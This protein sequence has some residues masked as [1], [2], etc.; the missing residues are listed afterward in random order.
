MDVLGG[1]SVTP[2]HGDRVRRASLALLLTVG[3]VG[4]AATSERDDERDRFIEQE[5]TWSPCPEHSGVECGSLEVPVDH[6]RPEGDTLDVALY[7]LPGPADDAG[8]IV[9]LPGGPGRRGVDLMD[10]YSPVRTLQRTH[11]VV[12]YDARAIGATSSFLCESEEAFRTHLSLDRTPDTAEEETA[13]VMSW[14]A[15]A[16]GCSDAAGDL[17][18]F[19]GTRDLVQDLDVLRAALGEDSL[20]FYGLSYGTLVGSEY[21]RAFPERV[22]RAALDAPR[23]AEDVSSADSLLELADAAER[24]FDEALEQCFVNPFLPCPLG[25]TP[26]EARASVESLLATLDAEPVELPDGGR[27]TREL[28]VSALHGGV[29]GGP[30]AWAP[31]IT[32]LGRAHQGEWNDLVDLTGELEDQPWVTAATV[33]TCA[34]LGPPQERVPEVRERARVLATRSPVF[35]ET[36]AWGELNCTGWPVGPTLDVATGP[37]DPAGDVLV[38]VSERDPLTPPSFV[39]HMTRQMG[40]ARLHTYTGPE[41]VAYVASDC[42]RMAIDDFLAH[43]RWPASDTCGTTPGR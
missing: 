30:D 41:H 21:A 28:A 16:G 7:R 37:V 35:G 25:T 43:A 4:C 38:V 2:A 5:I 40:G 26:Q 36:F 14:E 6:T 42:A 22:R 20:T 13:L 29:S 12:T 8:S 11:H 1:S 23:T 15:L 10:R 34:D 27:F 3:L 18:G 24:S 39:D 31:T 32:A 9:L 17:L 33:I 19:V